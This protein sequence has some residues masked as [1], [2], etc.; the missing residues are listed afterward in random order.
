MFSWEYSNRY[1]YEYDFSFLNN[2][3]AFPTKRMKY[4]NAEY[5]FRKKQFSGKY[6][7][8][9][10]LIAL[11]NKQEKNIPYTVISLNYYKLLTN[12]I[13]DLIFNNEVTIK[14]GSNE[15]DIL[16][17]KVVDNTKWIKSVRKAVKNTTIYG[18]CYIKTFR[19]GASVFDPT[20][21]FK[22]VSDSDVDTVKAYVLWQPIK[23]RK[24]DGLIDSTSVR[25]IRFEIHFK[26]YI[27][28]CVKMYSGGFNAGTIG[29]NIEY[30]YNGRVIAKDGNW[31]E[32]G[33]PDDF[34]VQSLTVNQEVD[35]VYGESIYQDI[36]DI[37]TAL[38][39]RIS[40]EHYALNSL[41]DPLLIVGMSSI[42]ED[43]NGNYELKTVNGNMLVTEDRN[44]DKAIIPQSFQQDFELGAYADFIDQLKSEL[45]E[46]S[47]LGRVFLSSEYSGNI[48][49][50][51]IS[52]L[53]KGAIDKANRI[54]N[55]CYDSLVDSLYV[56]AITNDIK[57]NKSDLLINFNIGQTDNDKNIADVCQI[58]SSNKILS[59]Q[60]LREKYFGYSKEQSDEEQQQIDF[61]DGL[62]QQ[63]VDIGFQSGTLDNNIDENFNKDSKED[64]T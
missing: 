4:K 2:G 61:E 46:L 12:K 33:I 3:N 47:E 19:N 23:E 32:T 17:N 54:L 6:G 50:E 10:Y 7:D 36:Q 20:H 11:I 58:L 35:G 21:A 57:V 41:A 24:Y 1:D 42:I 8:N 22:V 44:N 63:K 37:V 14:T 30:T 13:I 48:S 53:I 62:T 27:Y 31:Y 60:T 64:E 28:E 34:M 39:H 51:S 26:G 38:E 45:Y 59:K 52:N 29:Q 56:L 55:D 49:E 40:M 5:R 18:D 43:E 25:Y 9:R 16:L 15:N